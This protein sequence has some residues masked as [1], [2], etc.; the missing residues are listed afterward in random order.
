MQRAS[1]GSRSSIE[2][3]NGS[4]L[5]QGSRGDQVLARIEADV[6]DEMIMEKVLLQ[7]AKQAGYVTA[8]SDE[9]ARQLEELKK[10]SRLSEPQLEQRLGVRPDGIR[11]EISNRWAISQ[12]VEN[13]VL[14]DNSEDRDTAFRNYFSAAM[15]KAKVERFEKPN[16]DSKAQASCCAPGGGCGGGKPQAALPVDIHKDA[17][18]KA[19]EYYEK[20]TQKTGAEARVTDFGCHIQ[21]DIVEAGKVVL[22]LTYSQGVVEET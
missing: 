6:L 1:T 4:G 21:V 12:Y 18:E 10:M 9:V 19:L 3:Q 5:F 7:E 16:P 8:P 11:S 22:S 15:Q 2:D 13:V 14:K 17:K 20:K